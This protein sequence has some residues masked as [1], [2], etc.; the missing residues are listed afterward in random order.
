MA[1]RVL[2]AGGAG[3]VGSAVARQLLTEGAEVAVVD[4]LAPQGDGRAVREAR[5]EALRAFPR[6]TVLA[7]DLALPGA[8]D[9]VFRDIA[10]GAVV[11]A[12]LFAPGATG[13]EAMLEAA[14]RHGRPFLVHL[15]DGAL[16]GA[17]AEPGRPASEEEPIDPGRDPLLLSRLVEE[18]RVNGSELPGVILRL[19]GV[20]AAGAPAGRFPN[21]ALEKLLDGEEVV[22]PSDA[23]VDLLD[24]RDAVHGILA[25]LALRPAGRTLN[26][27]SGR[28]VAPSRVVRLLA[29]R[30]F[31][32][33]RI[34]VEGSGARAPRVASLERAGSLLRFRPRTPLE[35]TLDGVV[36]ARLGAPETST[37][38]PRAPE[39]PPGPEPARQTGPEAPRE[40]SRRELFGLFRRPGGDRRPR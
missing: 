7:A 37:S 10:P 8:A 11:N 24:V 1:F 13:V 26:L 39:R 9:E 12:A 16:Y 33:A 4:A 20:V 25:A 22:L 31:R 36:A 30:A 27:G 23:P 15:S 3:L 32:Q 14:L 6:A 2:V 19:F 5:L 38:R 35:T 29:E 21:G 17:P 40:V 18:S 34:R 28:G